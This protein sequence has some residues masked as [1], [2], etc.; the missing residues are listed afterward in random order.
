MPSK[1]I[2]ASGVQLLFQVLAF[3]GVVELNP[4]EHLAITAGLLA[5]AGIFQRMATAK[6]IKAASRG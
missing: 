4:D 5:A 2:V 6:A 3:Y 1:T